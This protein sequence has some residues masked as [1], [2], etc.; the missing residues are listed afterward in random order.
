MRCDIPLDMDTIRK[1]IGRRAAYLMR[2]TD[3]NYCAHF[4]TGT[5]RFSTRST[6][7]DRLW[8]S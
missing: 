4:C 5:G 7:K 1:L 3:A 2:L 8:R 6:D